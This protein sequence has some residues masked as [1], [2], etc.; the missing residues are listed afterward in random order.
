M[1]LEAKLH[2]VDDSTDK[3]RIWQRYSTLNGGPLMTEKE[4]H[5]SLGFNLQTQKYNINF[6][7]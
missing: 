4:L 7:L 3:L 2:A 5:L 1:S 6:H